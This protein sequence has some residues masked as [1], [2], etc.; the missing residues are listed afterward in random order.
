MTEITDADLDE[1]E[2]QLTEGEWAQSTRQVVSRL[3]KALRT[4]RHERDRLKAINAE[5]L[6]ALEYYAGDV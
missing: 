6:A 3:T 2:R 5:L 1:W 4:Y